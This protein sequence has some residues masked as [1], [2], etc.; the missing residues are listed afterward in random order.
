[1]ENLEI[2]L[3]KGR[4]KIPWYLFDCVCQAGREI[5]ADVL[6]KHL[7]EKER[8]VSA[9]EIF[10][11]WKSARIGRRESKRSAKQVSPMENSIES[12][13]VNLSWLSFTHFLVRF[14]RFP[15][16]DAD[17][18]VLLLVEA[19]P[20]EWTGRVGKIREKTKSNYSNAK[21]FVYRSDDRA[22]LKL[23]IKIF[24]DSDEF[25][26]FF[27]WLVTKLDFYLLWLVTHKAQWEPVGRSSG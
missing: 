25:S 20:D 2:L 10:C 14:A 23:L 9:R 27:F 15:L 26:L 22:I 3:W 6:N 8:S 1:M 4:E 12:P 5:E 13:M 18:R 24:V 17:L 16:L 21:C 19:R 7:E 11:C